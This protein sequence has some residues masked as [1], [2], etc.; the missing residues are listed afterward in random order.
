[1]LHKV[2]G[3]FFRSSYT[4]FSSKCNLEVPLARLFQEST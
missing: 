2:D 4:K 3:F 1:M